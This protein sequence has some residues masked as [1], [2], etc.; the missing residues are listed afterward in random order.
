MNENELNP[1]PQLEPQP[2]ERSGETLSRYTA[3]AFL[4]MAL[5]LLV[6]FGVSIVG[7]VTLLPLYILAINEY[8]LIVLTVLEL[9]VVIVLSAKLHSMPIGA[10]RALFL[11][12]ALLN[13]VVF[14]TYFFVF[15]LSSMVLAFGAAAL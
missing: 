1:Q 5:G 10:A 2:M 11:V 12:Y 13:G 14:S 7:Y 3:Q 6:T 8:A 4:W 15:E 9:I